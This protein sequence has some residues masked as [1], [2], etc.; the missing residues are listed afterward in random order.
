MTS[1]P[2]PAL[3]LPI[4]PQPQAHDWLEAVAFI[5]RFTALPRN[6]ALEWAQMHNAAALSRSTSL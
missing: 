2:P 5:C 1:D 3:L 4:E 6:P